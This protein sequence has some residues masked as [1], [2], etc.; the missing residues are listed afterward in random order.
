M[1]HTNPQEKS[2]GNSFLVTILLEDVAA[3]LD[4]V[5]RLGVVLKYFDAHPS[6]RLV[7]MEFVDQ[8]GLSF[9]IQTQNCEQL[10]L[11]LGSNGFPK[12]NGATS[13]GR[14]HIPIT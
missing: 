9:V 3:L 5:N 2:F 1:S 12:T 7:L 13:G 11:L 6:R 8:N 14:R 10:R 4:L